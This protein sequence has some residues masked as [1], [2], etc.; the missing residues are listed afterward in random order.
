MRLEEIYIN[1]KSTDT[2]WDR[3]SDL[4]IIASSW[5]YFKNR[6]FTADWKKAEDK[7]GGRHVAAAH[8]AISYKIHRILFLRNAKYSC[9][10]LEPYSPLENRLLKIDGNVCVMQCGEKRPMAR[11]TCGIFE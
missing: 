6:E 10:S 7:I 1:E 4:P 2:S 5:F 9:K 11:N 3:T 8:C